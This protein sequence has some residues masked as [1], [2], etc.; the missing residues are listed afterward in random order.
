ME[1]E[2]RELEEEEGREDVDEELE[3]EEVE[4][5]KINEESVEE[6]DIFVGGGELEE[7]DEGADNERSF[8][9]GEPS[10]KLHV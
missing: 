2:A 9:G 6:G 3:D 5:D 7:E 4:D 10:S 1:V 8:S